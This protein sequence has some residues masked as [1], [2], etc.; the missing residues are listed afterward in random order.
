MAAALLVGAAVA[1]RN[2]YRSGQHGFYLV[3]EAGCPENVVADGADTEL[4]GADELAYDTGLDS[5]AA[6]PG[7]F[8]S[9]GAGGAPAAAA[10]PPASFF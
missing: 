5:F 1:G 9:F 2:Y 4:L 6:G 3:D 7:G 8:S 10:P